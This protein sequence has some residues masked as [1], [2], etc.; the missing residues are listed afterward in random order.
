VSAIQRVEIARRD[1]L[2][3]TDD[4]HIC[5]QPGYDPVLHRCLGCADLPARLA[6]V[7]RE[8]DIATLKAECMERAYD[9]LMLC[10][11]H[12]DKANG[13]CLVCVAEE[14]TRREMREDRAEA[15][16]AALLTLRQQQER[17]VEAATLVANS[18]DDVAAIGWAK[19]IDE[20]H[21]AQSNAATLRLALPAETGAPQ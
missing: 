10:S 16:E 13:R 6:Q 15:A 5:G 14:R 21:W 2:M 17:L 12:R 9:R 1:F 3:P 19:S 8:R 11:D 7:E 20:R 4:L 18:L